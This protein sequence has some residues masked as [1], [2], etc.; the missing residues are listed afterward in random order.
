MFR[1]LKMKKFYLAVLFSIFST[2]FVFAIQAQTKKQ[3]FD[4]DL[5]AWTLKTGARKMPKSK[6]IFLAN[7]FG[8][9]ADQTF[10]STK[11]IQKAIDEAAKKGGV[12]SFEKGV[13]LT[14]TLF[15]KSNVHLKVDEGVTLLASHDENLYPRKPTRIAGIEMTW[16]SA[17]INVENAENVKISGLGVIDGNGKKWWDKYWALRKE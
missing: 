15:I 16:L 17:M 7:S 11:A 4:K 13:Y 6:K 14:G 5:P 3:S 10:D 9:K 1:S 8:A 12:V 2:V